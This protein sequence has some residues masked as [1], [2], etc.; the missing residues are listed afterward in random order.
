MKRVA[1][2]VLGIAVLGAVLLTWVF[3]AKTFY[4][5]KLE[6]QFTFDGDPYVATGFMEC[7]YQSSLFSLFA[8]KRP[9]PADGPPIFSG[10]YTETV[11]DAASVVLSDGK[12]AIL[13]KDGVKCQPLPQLQKLLATKR[14]DYGGSSIPA[15]YFPDRN[16]SKTVWALRDRR[17]AHGDSGRLVLQQFRIILVDEPIAPTL[18]QN[19]PAAWKWYEEYSAKYRKAMRGGGGSNES[20]DAIWRGLYG[21]VVLEDEWQGQRDFVEAATS[22]STVSIVNLKQ[23]GM[24]RARNCA[25]NVRTPQISLIPSDDYS[26]ATFDLDRSDLRWATITAPYVAK[27]RDRSTGRW[28]PRVCVVGEGCIEAIGVTALWI[29]LPK[30]RAFVRLENE[31]LEAFRFPDFALRQG[32]SL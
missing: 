2:I 10:Y 4:R 22:V 31:R 20:E 21:C 27:Y 28:R 3:S 16:D 26:M 18:A 29:Y 7:T 14:E 17:P 11:R 32:D 25:S 5:F 13:F 23:P 15:Y 9:H 8:R 6:A 1:W 30:R 24:D 12:G 19:V